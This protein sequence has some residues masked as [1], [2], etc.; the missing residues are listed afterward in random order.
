MHKLQLPG[1][2]AELAAVGG[3]EVQQR[4]IAKRARPVAVPHVATRISLRAQ[5]RNAELPQGI[6]SEGRQGVILADPLSSIHSVE[7]S[8]QIKREIGSAPL[9]QP[10]SARRAQP[11]GTAPITQCLFNSQVREKSMNS[12]ITVA[13]EVRLNWIACLRDPHPDV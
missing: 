13:Q 9:P 1:L 6:S 12:F 7:P 4:R 10:S 3:E 2:I 11:E 8:T 5:G